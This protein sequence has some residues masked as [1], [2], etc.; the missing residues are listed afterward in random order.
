[1]K[2]LVIIILLSFLFSLSIYAKKK[3]AFLVGISNY[4]ALDKDNEWNDIHGVND[5]LLITP[6]LEKQGFSIYTLIDSA[7]TYNNIT[8][9]FRRL[10]KFLK[11]GD[12]VYL[13]FSC[14]GQPFED[15]N[16][17]EEDGW[18]E[19]LVPIDAKIAYQKGAYEGSKH[20][21][22]DEL[23][24][25]VDMIRNKL[26]GTGQLFVTIDACHAGTASKGGLE[27][28]TRGTK[29]G[30]SPNG[31]IFSPKKKIENHYI[32]PLSPLKA[33]TVYLEACRSYQ[34][35]VEI[36]EDGTHYGALSYYIHKVLS[37]N[38]LDGDIQWIYE[39]ESLMKKDIRLRNQNMVIEVSK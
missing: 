7:A 9:Y 33:F 3:Y 17:D 28:I 30:F 19:S 13:H 35:N 25:H 21:L 29:R 22:D 11:K 34:T 39:V 27:V 16:G 18:D 37:N 31:V 1:M 2:V 8:S 32:I 15:M 12:I 6:I 24:G 5:I 26:G 20:L 23:N 10:F 4:H 38:N 36:V 14:H